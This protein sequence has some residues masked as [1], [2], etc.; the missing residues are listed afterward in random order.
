MDVTSTQASGLEH[1]ECVTDA[2]VEIMRAACGL[3]LR[4]Q[5]DTVEQ[6][7]TDGVIIGVISI[8]G[9]VDWS[10]FLGLPRQTATALVQQF[11]GFAVPF[12]SEDMGDAVGEMT[13][14]LAGEVKRR[15]ADRSVSVTISLPS[16]I[17]AEDLHVVVQ[18]NSAL[19]KTWFASDAG[20]L[21]TGVVFAKEGGFI[22]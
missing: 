10:L 9:D 6:T 14:V 4:A 11:A 18:R 19:T 12:D 1:F 8:V 16:V 15:L 21:W 13:N 5:E 7:V 2:T 22:A 20:A 17:R 3:E